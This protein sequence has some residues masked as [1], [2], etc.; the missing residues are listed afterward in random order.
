MSLEQE[1]LRYGIQNFCFNTRINC[2]EERKKIIFEHYK[3]IF[4]KRL[5]E[6]YDVEITSEIDLILKELIDYYY[7]NG[8]NTRISDFLGKKAKTVLNEKKMDFDADIFEREDKIRSHYK[9]F[10]FK[11]MQE[12]NKSRVLDDD[13]VL[14]LSSDI[15]NQL[16]NSYVKSDKSSAIDNYLNSGIRRKILC[17]E[18]E[19]K[20]LYDYFIRFGLTKDIV[21]YFYEK[22]IRYE[23]LAGYDLTKK[24]YL[25]LIEEILNNI[26]SLHFVFKTKLIKK[27]REINKERN[28]DRLDIVEE[29]K[30]GNFDNVELLRCL[31]SNIIDLMFDKFKDK[32]YVSN[33]EFKK[34]LKQKYDEYFDKTV[35]K[36]Y[37]DGN[38][39]FQ[40]YINVRLTN[41]CKN[42]KKLNSNFFVDEKE[43]DY[44]I[45]SNE[46]LIDV[47]FEKYK[48]KISPSDVLEDI[49][50]ESYY[51]SAEEY[52]K[53]KRKRDFAS[54]VDYKMN[55]YVKKM[56]L[57]K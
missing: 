8:L 17:Y 1:L 35:V 39:N 41:F 12:V 50:I 18:N 48:K 7:E 29:I 57:N 25:I 15:V 19:E 45:K 9:F 56:N 55:S 31:Y 49:I 47:V 40:R 21:N 27:V 26:S 51:K 4:E 43:K 34:I 33:E 5:L 53:N 42:N 22:S 13:E 54:Y 20:L 44:T 3:P 10:L 36:L 23:E 37:N 6:N 14:R 32:V 52:F 2:T 24:E 46:S 38:V 30:Y 28:Y 16:L 11:K